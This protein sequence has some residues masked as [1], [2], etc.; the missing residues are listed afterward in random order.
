MCVVHMSSR[1]SRMLTESGW[2]AVRRRRRR[3]K[4][5]A[6]NTKARW[7]RTCQTHFSGALFVWISLSRIFHRVS[8]NE[9]WNH[10]QT[11]SMRARIRRELRIKYFATSALRLQTQMYIGTGGACD[12]YFKR[13][14]RYRNKKFWNRCNITEKR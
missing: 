3:Q 10:V 4:I 7:R 6:N 5:A 9:N 8:L 14:I 2:A 1:N 11:G 13:I 12:G